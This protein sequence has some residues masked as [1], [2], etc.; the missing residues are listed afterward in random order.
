MNITTF[1]T[2]GIVGITHS[3]KFGGLLL[4]KNNRPDWNA[5]PFTADIG[6]NAYM[7][8]QR[9]VDSLPIL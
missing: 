2:I 6:P 4:F 5:T 3:Q 8:F 9:F 7:L 1:G